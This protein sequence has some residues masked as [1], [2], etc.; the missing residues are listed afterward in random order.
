MPS[1]AKP[2]Q[3]LFHLFED[4]PCWMIEP[5]AAK[6]QYSVPSVR[7]FLTGIGYFSSFT[8]N[9]R[10]DTLHTIPRFGRDGLWFEND[11]GFSRAGSLTST[12]VEL[13][14]RSPAGMTADQLG[15]KLRCRCHS[16]LVQ[17]YRQGKIARQ[18]LGHSYVYLAVDPTTAASQRQAI[19]NL[20]PTQL[21]AEIALLVLVEC[22]HHPE[23]SVKQLAKA[24]TRRTHVIIDVAQIERLFAQHGLKKTTRIVAATPCGR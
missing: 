14:N 23:L 16:V 18:K 13:T 3:H 20:P 5:L 12:L 9:G 4:Q 24:I 10:W 22:I 17:L 2:S 19:H 7:R 21:P 11:I 8:H 6:L 1:D 15:E